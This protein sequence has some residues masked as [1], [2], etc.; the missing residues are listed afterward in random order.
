LLVDPQLAARDFWVELDHPVV[1]AMT[2]PREGIYC[3]DMPPP[4]KAAPLLGEDNKR[5][6]SGELGYNDNDLEVLRTAGVI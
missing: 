4:R 3:A 2:Y 6:Y 1:G 5:V